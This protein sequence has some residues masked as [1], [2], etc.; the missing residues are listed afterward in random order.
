MLFVTSGCVANKAPALANVRATA[1]ASEYRDRALVLEDKGEVQRA[2]FSWQV[3][4]S[5]LPEDAE[6]Q[7]K[8]DSLQAL[9]REKATE[10]YNKA[11]EF[12]EQDQWQ[13]ALHQAVISL[14]YQ[15]GHEKALTMI[16]RERNMVRHK[17]Q[18]GESLVTIAEQYFNDPGKASIIAYFNDLPS[19]ATPVIPGMLLDFPQLPKLEVVQPKK[20]TLEIDALLVQARKGFKKS[21]HSQV[22][23]LTCRILKEMNTFRIE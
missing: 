12:A 5:L 9:A 19:A 15:P 4:R 16:N 3:V 6:A 13:S 17:V 21:E 2:I 18:Q 1:L 20:D 10:H 22:M 7:K 14:R 11:V 23:G 8:I